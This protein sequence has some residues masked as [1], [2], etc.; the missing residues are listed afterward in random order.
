M[1]LLSFVVYVLLQ[2]LCLPLL[3][4]GVVLK[5]SAARCQ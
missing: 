4:V 2:V 3:I 1:K 5:L